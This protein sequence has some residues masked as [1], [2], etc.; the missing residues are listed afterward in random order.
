MPEYTQKHCPCCGD[1]LTIIREDLY[2]HEPN[3]D[4]PL[5]RHEEEGDIWNRIGAAI[6]MAIKED[7][8]ENGKQLPHIG[9]LPVYDINDLKAI[10]ARVP[11]NTALSLASD[12]TVYVEAKFNTALSR[13]QV[14]I[15]SYTGA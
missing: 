1:K 7:R 9:P 15:L 13:Y 5:S 11:N 14:S 2:F 3:K 6:Q 12:S 8:E 4:C 10:I